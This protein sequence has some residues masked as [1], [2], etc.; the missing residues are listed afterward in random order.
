MRSP[1]QQT[2]RDLT[3][4]RIASASRSALWW[5]MCIRSHTL[6]LALA[7]TFGLLSTLGL[8]AQ[9][10]RE[11]VLPLDG[12][13]AED[14]TSLSLSWF[15]AQP[16]RVGS[17]TVKRRTYGQLGGNTWQ[18][19][20][21][22]LGPVMRFEDTSI[23]PG[24][25]YEY[26]VLRTARQI[27]DVGY[28]IA[29]TQLP[30]T[31]QRGI[32]YI[33]TD[34]TI[35]QAITPRLDRFTRDL[36]GDGWRV[37]HHS[38][39]RGDSTAPDQ[40]IRN[41]LALRQWLEARYRDDPFGNHV[42]V[43]VG[44]LPIIKSGEANPDG[45][46]RVA[47]AT[48]LIYADM[49][50]RWS[51]TIKG[52]VLNNQVP[53]DFIE[54]QIGRI[55]FSP[56]SGGDLETEIRHIRAYFD[57][58]HH[59]RMGYMGDLREAYGNNGHLVAENAGLRPIVGP[60][61]IAPGGHHDVGEEKPWLWGV[62]FGDWNGPVYAEKYANKAAFTINFGSHKQRF[63]VPFNP[64]TGLLAQPWYPISVGWGGRPAWWLHHM[65]LGG[66]IGDVHMR[67]VN[68]GRAKEPYQQSMDYFPPGR[69]LMRNS[70]WVN[71]LGDPTLRAFMLAPPRDVTAR[72][73]GQ[74][75]ALSWTPSPDPDTQGYRI[76][77]AA[78]DSDDFTLLSGPDPITQTVFTDES[79]LPD[80]RYMVRAYGLKRVYAGSFYT[81][82]Q[83]VYMALSPTTETLS[84][85]PEAIQTPKG[86]SIRLPDAFHQVQ[87]GA[88]HAFLKGP[89]Q[90]RL[91]QDADGWLYTPPD[92][93]S[94]TV[95]LGYS[96]S[97]AAP[98]A[99]D[100][101]RITVGN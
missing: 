22:A 3:K 51:A 9:E 11:K 29:G 81:L 80:G 85:P 20:S 54:M 79:P 21:G 27:V 52:R 64:M 88:I 18:T 100:I 63:H 33:V 91:T 92:G 55:D 58:N 31:E 83:G 65:A 82:S 86:Q 75:V 57:K 40:D 25:A 56:V 8:A 43:L 16:P 1:E 97:G 96:T 98:R 87:N 24:V 95:D 67:T 28:W 5:G 74:G 44:H 7:L 36:V 78:K 73:A 38:A 53:D 6:T 101:L 15:E 49:D 35:A 68:N 99:T 10:I 90:G 84:G 37:V 39:P 66:T 93:F 69:Y 4:Q 77:R 94:G 13:I 14:G 61:N 19:L 2:Q 46:E 50:G 34:D 26:Q 47:Q 42:V 60:G 30:A 62:A 72:T 89:A 17:V 76:F 23:T 48:D 59:W 32:V 70:V 71:L 45:H 41:A 12:Q